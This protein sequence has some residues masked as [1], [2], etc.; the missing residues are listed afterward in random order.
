MYS[1]VAGVIHS[2]ACMPA[3]IHMMGLVSPSAV[4]IC[5]LTSFNHP[6]CTYKHENIRLHPIWRINSKLFVGRYGVV[7]Y[8]A[9]GK[10]SWII[11]GATSSCAANH[12]MYMHIDLSMEDYN[13]SYL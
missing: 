6:N 12:N 7:Q 1:T 2:R 11:I 10:L 8:S 4:P 13:Q 5:R 9:M 3:S